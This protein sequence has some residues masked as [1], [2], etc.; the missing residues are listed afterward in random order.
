M[1]TTFGNYEMLSGNLASIGTGGIIAVTT[2]LIW[3]ED[4][5]FE[6]TRAIN[7]PSHNLMEKEGIERE[8]GEYM[9]EKKRVASE[10]STEPIT[11]N[12]FWLG[13]GGGRSCT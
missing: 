7:T 13:D 8:S 1:Q 6:A 2:S 5:D 3:P 4:F 10:V 12:D 9:D 11:P